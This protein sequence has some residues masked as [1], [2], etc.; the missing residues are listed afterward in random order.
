MQRGR[1][2]CCVSE[3]WEVTRDHLDGQVTF[4]LEANTGFCF[5]DLSN[6]FGVPGWVLGMRAD[7]RNVPDCVG[8]TFKGAWMGGRQG[9][10]NEAGTIS[11]SDQACA[12]W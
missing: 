2:P 12:D 6:S 1:V 4:E 9:L 8:L 10:R 7:E 5:F 11:D 3:L